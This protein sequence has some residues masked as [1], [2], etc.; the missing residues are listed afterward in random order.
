MRRSCI[1]VLV[2]WGLVSHAVPPPAAAVAADSLAA[3]ARKDTVKVG[4]WT[5]TG[6]IQKPQPEAGIS[7]EE[8]EEIKDE[9]A[10]IGRREVGGGLRQWQRR[11]VPKVAWLSSVVLPGLGQVYNGRRIKVV[12]AAGIFTFYASSAWLHWK[13][14]QAL[15]AYRDN[16]PDNV[17]GGVIFNLDQQIEFEKESSRDY[18]WWS[19][20]VWVI[21]MLDAW[22][23]AHLYDLRVYTPPATI[24][25]SQANLR[26]ESRHY[27]TLSI[28][29]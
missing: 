4:G 24:G 23:D 8:R 13:N 6:D 18:V 1:C 17:S 26:P 15:T 29:F 28:L 5:I 21:V 25:D 7:E 3:P 12:L 11:K 27:L 19:G 9:L 22:V 2:I 10:Q 20:A 14:A 16:L